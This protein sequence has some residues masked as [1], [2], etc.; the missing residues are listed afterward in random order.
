MTL[1]TIYLR[2]KLKKL[3]SFWRSIWWIRLQLSQLYKSIIIPERHVSDFSPVCFRVRVELLERFRRTDMNV[4][5]PVGI[6]WFRLQL[7]SERNVSKGVFFCIVKWIKVSVAVHSSIQLEINSLRHSALWISLTDTESDTFLHFAIYLDVLA[8]DV[9][10]AAADIA[11]QSVHITFHRQFDFLR[12]R[13]SF[14]DL[15]GF[16]LG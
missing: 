10:V 15:L 1:K 13:P 7:Q 2:I 14:S 8:F 12:D 3:H 9:D 5:K 4:P 6:L 11:H 16:R